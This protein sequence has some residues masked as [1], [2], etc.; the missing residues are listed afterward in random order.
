MLR[1][2]CLL[3]AAIGVCF[4]SSATAAE[5][6]AAKIEFQRVK[7]DPAF[8]SEGVAVG[9]FNKD[10]KL[11]IAAG[12]VY[13]AAP[14]W[15][16]NAILEK[17]LEYNPL[18]YSVSF[19]NW[20]EDINGDGWTDL[21]VV[22]FPG[23]QTWWYENPQTAGGPW[24]QHTCV[25]VTNN[26]SPTFLDLDGDGRRELIFGTSPDPKQFDGPQR[27]MAIARPKADGLWPIQSISKPAAPSTQRYSHG[28][29]VGDVNKDGLND[30]LVPQGWWQNPGK[31]DSGNPKVGEWAFH[32]VN[33]G[34]PCAHMYVYDFDGDGDN[35]VLSSSAHKFGIWWHEQSPDGWKTHEI[36]KSF[37]ET[38][39]V[40][41]ADMNGDGLMDFVTGKRW[42]SHANREPGADMP[43][44][45]C[46]FELQRKE[47]KPV[48]TRHQ[49]DHDSGI[50]TQFEVA[51]LNADGLLD[52][53]S[54][55]KKGTQC[56]LQ[57]R[58]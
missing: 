23:K 5:K 13:Y 52:I 24:K 1:F 8:R 48:W 43:A 53:I 29:G 4:V 9:D 12:S 50:G 16:M 57:V 34:Q 28:L 22:D 35:D 21:M 58:K 2:I 14:D 19:C 10:G 36:D 40:C 44:V 27:T 33:Y 3:A 7:I 32:E 6:S 25:E 37:S 41:L 39:S 46:W 20:A 49:V 18:N 38:H 30:I 56:F 42:W 26:E 11:D 54:S 55:N 15:K 47:G 17:P 45:V 31:D 51:D